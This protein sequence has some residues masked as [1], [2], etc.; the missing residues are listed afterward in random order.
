MTV[1]IAEQTVAGLRWVVVA[2]PRLAAFRALGGLARDEIHEVVESM[3][4]R[5]ALERFVATTQGRAVLGRVVA[6]EAGAFARGE[7]RLRRAK[8]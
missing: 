5:Q 4:E 2:G 6:E 3:P 7:C 8:D 1:S